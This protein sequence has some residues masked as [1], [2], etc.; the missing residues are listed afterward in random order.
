MSNPI[1]FDRQHNLA[2]ATSVNRDNNTVY[3]PYDGI[4]IVV[5]GKEFGCDTATLNRIS[6]VEAQ[7]SAAS[8]SANAAQAAA[9]NAA[10]SLEDLEAAIQNLPDG[11]AVSAQVGLMQ[12]HKT[13]IIDL[14][15]ITA[16]SGSNI[17]HDCNG[18]TIDAGKCH[19][20]YSKEVSGAL[21][22]RMCE[23]EVY[24]YHSEYN[25]V[26]K[27]KVENTQEYPHD[28]K[29]WVFSGEFPW[30]CTN[31]YDESNVPSNY[32]KIFPSNMME[33]KIEAAYY[34][35][36][37]GAQSNFTPVSAGSSLGYYSLSKT[38]TTVS[39]IYNTLQGNWQNKLIPIVTMTL[40]SHN[41]DPYTIAMY[42]AGNSSFIGSIKGYNG[43][44][45]VRVKSTSTSCEAHIETTFS[46][47]VPTSAELESVIDEINII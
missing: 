34:L 35:M 1:K 27:A 40:G 26:A 44:Y 4:S 41:S 7:V 29:Y 38:G 9:A 18:D 15:S 45:I 21:R 3:F 28:Y 23:V 43:D 25:I 42:K 31:T 13:E 12:S 19:F 17:I 39:G 6:T 30:L 47:P 2:Y 46:N 32:R 33:D 5:N 16:E 20:V 8:A 11:Q 36:D 22:Y 10:A 24:S 14:R 37:L